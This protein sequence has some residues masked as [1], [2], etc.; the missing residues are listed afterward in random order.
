MTDGSAPGRPTS[1]DT[2]EPD[3]ADPTPEA[4]APEPALGLRGPLVLLLLGALWLGA[5]LWS[6]RTLVVTPDNSTESTAVQVALYLSSLAT[7]GLVTGAAA[8][9]VVRA[10]V[11]RRAGLTRLSGC[12][13]GGLAA[14][15]L[16]GIATRLIEQGDAEVTNVLAA[17]I[18][19][20]ALL[21][22][23]VAAAPSGR[24]VV[25]GLVGTVATLLVRF[26]QGLFDAP[27]TSLFGGGSGLASVAT[28]QD[29][30][31]LAA[32]L[33]AGVVAGVAVHGYLLRTAEPVRLG[34]RILAGGTAGL[35]SL[36]AEVIT[37]VAGNQLE[38]IARGVSE[39]DAIALELTRQARIN[40]ALVVLFAGAITAV[41]MYGRRR[42]S[43]APRADQPEPSDQ[44]EPADQPDPAEQPDPA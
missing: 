35:L 44:P 13:L 5:L 20:A 39:L 2:A 33:L 40:G 25:A 43:A 36:I 11:P 23:L 27:L 34:G 42:A 29:R 15:V 26:L 30:L 17:S 41:I 10:L 22:G 31:A 19:V 9:L 21:G 16:A 38:Q 28:A 1:T 32:S 18:G 3:A 37:W 7:A 6:L 24:L 14:A 8:G 4:V 12:L